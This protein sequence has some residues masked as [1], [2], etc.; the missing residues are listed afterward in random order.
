[1]REGK[2]EGVAASASS[3]RGR[4]TA[5]LLPRDPCPDCRTA[6]GATVDVDFSAEQRHSLPHAGMTET[7]PGAM[8]LGIKAGAVVG[9]SELQ[10]AVQAPYVNLNLACFGMACDIAQPFLRDAKEA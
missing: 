5:F 9:H 2:G 7:R 1:M 6:R 10:S 4:L 8:L 3:T